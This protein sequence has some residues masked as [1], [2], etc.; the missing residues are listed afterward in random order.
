M[1]E[2][3]LVKPSDRLRDVA[4]PV[5]NEV[6]AHTSRLLAEDP[7]NAEAHFHRGLALLE[8][9]DPVA[10][11]G[12]LRRALVV[13]L[14]AGAVSVVGSNNITSSTLEALRICAVV[15]MFTVLEQ[16]ITSVNKAKQILLAVFLASVIPILYTTYGFLIGHPKSDVKGGFTRIS[17]A[18]GAGGTGLKLNSPVFPGV[19]NLLLLLLPEE[20]IARVTEA[21]YRL[22][23]GYRLKPGMTLILQDAQ[24]PNKPRD[25]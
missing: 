9:G 22:Q 16:M 12:S 21:F 8:R 10:A 18:Q 24:I 17:G 2:A 23:A 13:F 1:K 20:Q 11:R 19:N 5:W 25:L 4:M 14:F 7:L 6:M 3:T 15:A